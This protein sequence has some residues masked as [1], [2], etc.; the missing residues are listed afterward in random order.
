MY[1]MATMGSSVCQFREEDVVYFDRCSLRENVKLQCS[2]RPYL[3][4]F[5]GEFMSYLC[6]LCLFA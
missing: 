5:V 3:Q 2:E 6:Y 4:L 1:S